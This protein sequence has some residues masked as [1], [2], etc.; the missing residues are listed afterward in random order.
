MLVKIHPWSLAI[1]PALLVLTLGC[2]AAQDDRFAP[3]FE[4]SG[5]VTLQGKP[6]ESGDIQFTS[7]AD[8]S[9]GSE[10]FGVIEN[11]KYSTQVTAGKK[12]VII[13]SPKA[14]GKPDET[15]FQP[16]VD[17]V[18]AKYNDASTLEVEITADAES[19]DFDLKK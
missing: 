10:A 19:V 12:Q 5:S 17:R 9:E 2:G 4:I 16:V 13:R 8:V 11:G 6:L 7:P 14:A 15:G 18:P 1:A 3:R